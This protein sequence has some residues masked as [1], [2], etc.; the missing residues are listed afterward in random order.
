MHIGLV[1]DLR[2]DYL[3]Q[4]LS[5]EE[6]AEFDSPVTI[7]ALV[8]TLTALGHRI[9]RIGNVQA[10]VQRLACGERWDLVFNIAEGLH[11]LGR[12]AVVP[13]LL[14]A[15][16]VPYTFSDPLVMTVSLH[17]PTT[18]RVLRDA[19]VATAPFTVVT[20]MEDVETVGLRYPLFAKPIAEGTSKGVTAASKVV[21]AAALRSVCAQLLQR[22]RQPVLVEEYLPGREF[23]VGLLGSGKDAE[24]LGALEIVLLPQADAE[25]YTFQNKERCEELVEYRLAT[26]PDAQAACAIALDAWRVLGC[27]DAGRVDVRFGAD[28]HPYVIEVNPLAG[29]HPSHSDLP[30]LATQLGIA[31]QDLIARIVAAATTRM[32]AKG[33]PRS[34]AVQ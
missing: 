8:E 16:D 31:Y 13:A 24:A 15:Y 29:L 19:G 12:E 21:D 23:T 33:A 5:E 20:T 26:D 10:L 34:A 18:K 32:V 17:K 7:D 27:R 3:A 4:G 14:E 2:Q 1:Y 25:V 28:G 9:D 6:T 30:I 11:G 22:Y